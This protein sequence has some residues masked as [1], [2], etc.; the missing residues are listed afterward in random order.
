MKK[1]IKNNLILFAIAGT[2][3][4]LAIA[5]LIFLAATDKLFEK[6]TPTATPTAVPTETINNTKAVT[7]TVTA[8]VATES[9][10]IKVTSPK[11][12]ENI[13]ELITIKGEARVFE[14]QFSIRIK[15]KDGKV[16]VNTTAQSN[17][18]DVGEFGPFE[19]TI[20]IEPQEAGTG[21]IEFFDISLKDGSEQDMVIIP[22]VFPPHYNQTPTM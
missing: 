3:I 17:A 16:I 5:A 18:P 8:T 9:L 15:D 7:P 2:I 13:G 6:P 14:G 1:R 10:N 20:T 4:L 22:I 11:P 12:Y 21:S 19:K